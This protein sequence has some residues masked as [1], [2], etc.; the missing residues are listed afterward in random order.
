MAEGIIATRLEINDNLPAAVNYLNLTNQVAGGAAQVKVEWGNPTQYF[1]GVAIVR[2]EG[3]APTGFT[4]GVIVYDGTG[5]SCT[6]PDVEEGKT[7]YYRA[8]TYNARRQ[9]QTNGTAKQILIQGT[10]DQSKIPNYG[11]LK[12]DEKTQGAQTY[13]KYGGVFLREK[14]QP[15]IYPKLEWSSRQTAI[16]NLVVAELQ[17]IISHIIE[18]RVAK[19]EEIGAVWDDKR[20]T[21][22]NT[23]SYVFYHTEIYETYV[24]G[25]YYAFRGINENGAASG[26]TSGVKGYASLAIKLDNYIQINPTPDYDGCYVLKK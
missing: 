4:D 15:T 8:Y 24:G 19:H 21:P 2:K 1:G 9:I 17:D 10:I 3:S 18:K 16:D 20:K 25:E 7:Y 11:K 13:H 23:S 26:Q 22:S 12:I 5:N 6:D 14:V